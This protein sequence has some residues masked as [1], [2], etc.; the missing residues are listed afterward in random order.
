M[1]S[2]IVPAGQDDRSFIENAR[3]AQ[4][5]ECAIDAIAELGYTNASLAEIAR[6][7]GISKGVISYH[8]A[9][10]GELIQQ[11]VNAV[12]E[13]AGAVMLPRIF[14]EHTEAGMLR[15]YIESNLEF[16]DSNRND[17]A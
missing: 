1:R 5:I 10:K 13:K 11:V 7:A 15:A 3:R 14:A 17:I 8:F 12:M 2:E 9:G 16:L 6:R 4:I